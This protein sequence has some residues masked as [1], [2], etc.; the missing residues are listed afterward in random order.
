MWPQSVWDFA[1]NV[2]LPAHSLRRERG[3]VYHRCYL[4]GR[5]LTGGGTRKSVCKMTRGTRRV[6]TSSLCPGDWQVAVQPFYGLPLFA[7][8]RLGR[9]RIPRDPVLG[10]I[11]R[12][13]GEDEG[14][15]TSHHALSAALAVSRCP[16]EQR[17]R[18]VRR[19]HQGHTGEPAVK[20]K[21]GGHSVGRGQPFLQ[22]RRGAGEGGRLRAPR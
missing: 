10:R 12:D 4:P 15:V 17:G 13:S 11:S 20:F 8:E 16:G 7:V 3:T 2:R 19:G 9:S 21:G 5:S 22:S 18:Q 14:C 1:Q 6:P